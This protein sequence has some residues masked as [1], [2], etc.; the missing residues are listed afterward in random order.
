MPKK[1]ETKSNKITVR[2]LSNDGW[3]TAKDRS[4]AK[5]T[6]KAK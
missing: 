5:A 2:A 4:A 6:A 1:R 3:K